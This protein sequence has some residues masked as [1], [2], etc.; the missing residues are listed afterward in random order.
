M[1]R[2]I[3]VERITRETAYYI[4]SIRSNKVDKFTKNIQQHWGIENRLHWVK[5]VSMKEDIS[6]MD[7]G[8]AAQNI[9]IMSNIT[10]NLF[11]II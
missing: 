4:S 5:N 1:K 7:K 9:S 3:R 6:K 8:N 10:I 2:I 11:R